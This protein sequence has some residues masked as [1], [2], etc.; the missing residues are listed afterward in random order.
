MARGV[1]WRVVLVGLLVAALCG[2]V[3]AQPKGGAAPEGPVLVMETAKGVVEIELF[4]KEA[5]RTVAH[6]LALV[7]RRF[8]HGQRIH[9]VEKNFVVQWGD[10][11]SRDMTKRDRWGR[12]GSGKPIGVAEISKKRSH[13]RGA[14]GMAHAGDPA[15][16][17]SQM[18]IMLADR[19]ALDGKYAVIGRVISGM[20]VVTKFEV[21]DLIKRISVKETAPS[22]P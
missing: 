3:A 4:E 7:K 16:A 20:D 19:P 5:P 18:Y 14:V 1:L 17:D 13:R 15:Q 9:R 2:A 8:Y 6:I 22:K 21:G 10:P 12:E 11:Q